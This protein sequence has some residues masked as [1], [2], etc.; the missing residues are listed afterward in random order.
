MPSMARRPSTRL[1]VVLGLTAVTGTAWWFG[2]DGDGPDNGPRI[3]VSGSI[4]GTVPRPTAPPI[5]G[6]NIRTD[7]AVLALDGSSHP[8]SE[9]VGTP[10]LINIW[11]SSCDPCRREMPALGALAEQYGGRLRV[12]GVDPLDS[13]GT[14]RDFV[15]EVGVAYDQYRDPDGLLQV[16]YGIADIPTSILVGADGTIIDVHIG[17]LELDELTEWVAQA[18]TPG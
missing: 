1:A 11:A 2:H 5:D 6:R 8:L 17:A 4:D 13:A 12:V 18:L 15:A 10:T 16:E 7:L 14:L 3:E 9:F